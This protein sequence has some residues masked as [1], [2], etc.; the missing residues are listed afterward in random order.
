MYTQNNPIRVCLQ[1]WQ[2]RVL[3]SCYA[4]RNALIRKAIS[5]SSPTISSWLITVQQT[6]D[7]PFSRCDT[8]NVIKM[9]L[10]KDTK[11][12][13]RTTGFSTNVNAVHYWEINAGYKSDL[14][15][16]LH[17]HIN[18]ESQLY[19]HKDLSP[20]RIQND[21]IDVSSVITVPI[22]IFIPPLSETNLL[23]IS[24]GIEALVSTAN[25]VIGAER[26]GEEL[27]ATFIKKK[28]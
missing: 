23:S 10:N 5:R 18:Y 28:G 24:T 14:R 27:M 16:C 3:P 11:T 15:G 1:P 20:S 8:E 12:P 25:E 7:N 17:E 13:G 6:N 22:E 19:Q 9:T 21:E 2:L 4:Q 26:K